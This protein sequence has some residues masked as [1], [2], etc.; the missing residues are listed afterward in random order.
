MRV[1]RTPKRFR[2]EEGLFGRAS[3]NLR[4]LA[5]GRSTWWSRSE[6]LLTE[7]HRILPELKVQ[8]VLYLNGTRSACEWQ[9]VFS[10]YECV[11]HRGGGKYFHIARNGWK[12]GWQA[13]SSL[14]SDKAS[15]LKEKGKGKVGGKKGRLVNKQNFK[16]RFTMKYIHQIGWIIVHRLILKEKKEIACRWIKCDHINEVIFKMKVLTKMN[17]SKYMD[18]IMFTNDT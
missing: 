17:C 5:K 7:G 13:I 18:G 10:M 1:I 14:L 16:W 3:P 9:K 6:Y 8:K 15:P 2:G 11:F 12:W 4:V